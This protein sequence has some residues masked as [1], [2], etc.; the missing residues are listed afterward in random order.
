MNTAYLGTAAMFFVFSALI[1]TGVASTYVIGAYQ[2]HVGQSANYVRVAFAILHVLLACVL[3]RPLKR[4]DATAHGKA[5]AVSALFL[6]NAA[7]ELLGMM[8]MRA[9]GWTRTETQICLLAVLT[10]SLL[11][12]LAYLLRASRQPA[13]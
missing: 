9:R 2:A 3:F 10:F 8:I 13:H 4:G 5:T 12:S 6:L 1:R 11:I 7:R